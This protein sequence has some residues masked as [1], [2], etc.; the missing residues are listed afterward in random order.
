VKITDK[1]WKWAQSALRFQSR[2]ERTAIMR[3]VQMSGRVVREAKYNVALAKVWRQQLP[4]C[5]VVVIP[6]RDA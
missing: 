4:N 3:Q 5:I 1:D 2:L 6:S